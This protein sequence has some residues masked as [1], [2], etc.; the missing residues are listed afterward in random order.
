MRIIRRATAPL[1][2][3]VVLT[4]GNFDG[5]HLGHRAILQRLAEA[6]RAFG[7]P[8]SV[9][10]FEPHPR[11]LFNPAAAP[12]RLTSLREKLQLLAEAGVDQVYLRRF[13]R[14]YAALTPADFIQQEVVGLGARWVMVGDDFRFGARRAGDVALLRAAGERHGFAVEG[15]PDV[16]SDGLRVSS[17]RVR[18]A[19]AAGRLDDATRLLG[20]PYSISGRVMHGRKLGRTLGFPT[21]NV[22]LRHNRPPCAGI[23]VVEVEGIAPRP[24]PAV[25]SLGKQPTVDQSGNYSL[26]VHLLDFDG[27]LYERH[28]RVDFLAW[29]RDEAR[30]DSLESLTA[31]IAADVV[32][33]RQYFADR[34]TG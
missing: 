1:P 12:T 27:D 34:S 7:L 4:I 3:G 25:A 10:T 5:V 17:T 24:W 28:V 14:T 2:A 23:F 22:Q 32:A 13:D 15:L 21:A 20:R 26:E 11:E 31:A 16:L 9:M 29:L 18:E 19:L 8:A 6:S 33:A 30:F